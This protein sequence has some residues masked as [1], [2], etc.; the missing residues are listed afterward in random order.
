MVIFFSKKGWK[1]MN[2]K[3]IQIALDEKGSNLF[4]F[5]INMSIKKSVWSD[6]GA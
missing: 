2:E 6:F 1:N 5:I 3:I 4:K